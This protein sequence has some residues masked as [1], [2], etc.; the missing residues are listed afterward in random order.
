MGFL[1]SL[2]NNPGSSLKRVA[3]NMLNNYNKQGNS[4]IP[5]SDV[6]FAEDISSIIHSDDIISYS[7]NG[8]RLQHI[9]N[10]MKLTY[11]GVLAKNGAKDIY[12]AIGYGDNNNWE[13]VEVYQLQKTAQQTFELLTF[14][15]RSGNINIAFKDSAGHWDNNNGQNFIFDDD[16]VKGSH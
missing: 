6:E 7:H 14:R 2:I 8:V 11:D 16:S 10:M 13:D 3:N 1:K 15:K 4:K 5:T 12:A 9:P